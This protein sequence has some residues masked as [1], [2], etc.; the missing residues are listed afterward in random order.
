MAAQKRSLSRNYIDLVEDEN[1]RRAAEGQ[2]VSPRPIKDYLL[3]LVAAMRSAR[4][5]AR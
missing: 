1:E 3:G 5:E 2:P 4:S